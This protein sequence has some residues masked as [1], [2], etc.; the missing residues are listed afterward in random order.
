M[1]WNLSTP[2]YSG[3]RLVNGQVK[4]TVTLSHTFVETRRQG[5]HKKIRGTPGFFL[6]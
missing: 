4:K 5:R 6:E 1:M 3:K 2:L